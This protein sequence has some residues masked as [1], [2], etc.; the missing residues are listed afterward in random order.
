M[1]KYKFKNTGIAELD[2][3]IAVLSINMPDIDFN[4]RRHYNP[5]PC[6]WAILDSPIPKDSDQIFSDLWAEE[7]EF[8]IEKFTESFNRKL[9][10]RNIPRADVLK[11]FIVN[12]VNY[13]VLG[14]SKKTNAV[15]MLGRRP[16][17]KQAKVWNG[18]EGYF[19]HEWHNSRRL[20]K[21]VI[22]DKFG[23]SK[24]EADE[25][26]CKYRK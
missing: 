15:L 22:R 20:S 23:L 1:Y 8:T 13:V 26:M 18:Q 17:F 3:K 9:T 25:F 16:L 4:T 12:G 2:G 6:L 10:G 11:H 19:W 7:D 14:L 21:V 24:L 5:R